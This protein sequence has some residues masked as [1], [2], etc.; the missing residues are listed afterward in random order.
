MSVLT[1][2]F[3][4]T[5]ATFPLAAL[6]ALA[7]PANETEAPQAKKEGG[8]GGIAALLGGQQSDESKE[9]GELQFDADTLEMDFN[10]RTG[11]FEGNVKVTD[12]RM[13]L[14]AD[15]M[16]VHLAEKNELEKIEATGNVVISEIG[17]QRKAKAGK[18]IFDVQKDE[19]TLS[20]NPTLEDVEWGVRKAEKMVYNRTKG[21]FKLYKVHGGG[22][23]D[24]GGHGPRDLFTPAKDG[25]TKD[26]EEPKS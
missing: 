14:L 1:T 8:T 7:Q 15:K 13:L 18:G 3:R 17:Q 2:T 16:T 26:K 11:T 4:T 12:G 19:I 22:M 21:T 23:I 24:D 25:K 6:L 5:L 10:N 20:D 9:T